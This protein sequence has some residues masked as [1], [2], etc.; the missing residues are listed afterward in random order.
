LLRG[1]AGVLWRGSVAFI[2]PNRRG[3]AGID[4]NGPKGAAVLDNCRTATV[5]QDIPAFARGL[6]Q[7]RNAR[8]AFVWLTVAP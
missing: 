8:N 5:G 4:P 6:S 7:S 2:L 1:G 3:K